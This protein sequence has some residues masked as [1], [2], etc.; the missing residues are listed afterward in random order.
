MNKVQ[1][2]LEVDELP[3]EVLFEYE[4]GNVATRQQP[5]SCPYLEIVSIGMDKATYAK[6]VEIAEAKLLKMRG[7]NGLSDTI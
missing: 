5:E 2:M 7:D 3:F 1:I 6:L 4:K